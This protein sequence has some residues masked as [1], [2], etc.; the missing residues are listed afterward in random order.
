MSVT[1]TLFNYLLLESLVPDLVSPQPVFLYG[2][3][4]YYVLLPRD[5]FL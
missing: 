3:H 2:L 4:E 5:S 1:G